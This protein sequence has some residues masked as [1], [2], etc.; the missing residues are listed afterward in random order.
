MAASEQ[1]WAG[2]SLQPLGAWVLMSKTSNETHPP[3]WGGTSWAEGLCTCLLGRW[4]LLE[5]REEQQ[6]WWAAGDR[7]NI[8]A[9]EP[10][11]RQ[12]NWCSAG[13]KTENITENFLPNLVKH[14]SLQIEETQQ[15]PN[16]INPKKSTP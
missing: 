5:L 12:K 9:T 2:V 10:P 11:E 8:N 13:K 1:P 6:G 3:N 7:S 15:I 16:K 14:I 4:W